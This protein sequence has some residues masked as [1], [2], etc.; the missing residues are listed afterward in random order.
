MQYL[1][2]KKYVATANSATVLDS[3]SIPVSFDIV[4]VAAHRMYCKPSKVS[5]LHVGILTFYIDKFTENLRNLM[6]TISIKKHALSEV[7]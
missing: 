5:A 7:F 2:L 3:N 4:K 1:C 6:V